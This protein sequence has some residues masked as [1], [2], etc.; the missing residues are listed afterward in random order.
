MPTEA[1]Y[2]K[3]LRVEAGLIDREVRAVLE[4]IRAL[5]PFLEHGRVKR[6][7]L[8]SRDT[9][10]EED[11][12][13]WVVDRD[14]DFVV[15]YL[16]VILRASR[17]SYLMDGFFVLEMGAG[18]GYHKKPNWGDFSEYSLEQLFPVTVGNAEEI[19]TAITIAVKQVF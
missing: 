13:E 5:L 18:A 6:R 16:R 10:E 2:Q 1:E 14:K 3:R 11:L 17:L 8:R 4:S 7:Y 15:R 12:V 9:G 19:R